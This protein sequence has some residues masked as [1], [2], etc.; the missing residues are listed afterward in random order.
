M[1]AG[2]LDS[3]GTGRAA[4]SGELGQR[5]LS[6]GSQGARGAPAQPPLSTPGPRRGG[7]GGSGSGAGP[8][9]AGGLPRAEAAR[10]TRAAFV[11]GEALQEF[12]S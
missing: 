10:G 8:C 12:A 6:A 7:A 3:A 11:R 1:P 5:G 4:G 9:G 2:T